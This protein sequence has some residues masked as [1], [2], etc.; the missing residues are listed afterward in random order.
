MSRG[1]ARLAP[2]SL[3]EGLLLAR[4]IGGTPESGLKKY[5]FLE[6]LA[7]GQRQ[8]GSL[9]WHPGAMGYRGDTSRPDDH[10]APAISLQRRLA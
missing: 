5:G 9:K 7:K 6:L 8:E 10:T 4:H 2:T 3:R 1:K